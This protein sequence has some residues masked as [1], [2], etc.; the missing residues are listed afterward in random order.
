MVIIRAAEGEISFRVP[1]PPP[2]RDFE[3]HFFS[4]LTMF[5][6]Y[7]KFQKTIQTF[8]G[9]FQKKVDNFKIFIEKWIWTFSKKIENRKNDFSIFRFFFRK[10]SYSFF[11]ENF[12]I[13]NFFFENFRKKCV[14]KKNVLKKNWTKIKKY[15]STQNFP[16]IPKIALRKPCDHYSNPR[17]GETCKI[18]SRF[19]SFGWLFIW[20]LWG[21]PKNWNF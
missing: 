15:M 9:N 14:S 1:R 3:I 12:E 19:L 17:E 21:F 6:F 2:A 18:G 8:F 11:N 7:W 4:Q 20:V 16:K 13:F 5:F 10:F